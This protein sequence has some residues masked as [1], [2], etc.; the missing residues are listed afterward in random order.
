MTLVGEF[1]FGHMIPKYATNLVDAEMLSQ[2]VEKTS[3]KVRL[4]VLDW[5]GIKGE[6]KPKLLLALETIGLPF[7]KV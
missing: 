4:A 6:D 2:C 1:A 5:K 7:K 3:E